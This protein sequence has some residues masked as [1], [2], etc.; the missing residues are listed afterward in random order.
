[1][2]CVLVLL[3][4]ALITRIGSGGGITTLIMEYIRDGCAAWSKACS[5]LFERVTNV[6]RDMCDLFAG[7]G[8]FTLIREWLSECVRA[9]LAGLAIV[10]NKSFIIGT[11]DCLN[12]A[13]SGCTVDR[14]MCKLQRLMTALVHVLYHDRVCV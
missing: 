13:K 2:L 1:M 8:P 5:A 7:V 10:Q 4:A 14:G 9:H 6:K 12:N 11:R 3:V